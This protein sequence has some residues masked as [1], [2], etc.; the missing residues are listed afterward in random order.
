MERYDFRSNR[1]TSV[2]FMGIRRKYL[3]VVVYNNMIYVVGGRDDITEFSS[4]ERYNF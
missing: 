3:G 1:W 2:S 4:A